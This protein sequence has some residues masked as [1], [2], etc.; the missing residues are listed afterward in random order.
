MQ[1]LTPWTAPDPVVRQLSDPQGFQKAVSPSGA[2]AK[3]ATIALVIGLLLLAYNLV[4][5]FRT[6]SEN[7]LGSESFFEVFTSTTGQNFSTDPMLVAYV[8]GPIVLIPL[9]IVFLVV[10]RLTVKQRAD[11]A[12]AAYSS[13]GYAAKALGL[14]VRFTANNSQVV[15][16][17]LVPPHLGSEEVS[18]WMSG[19]AQSITT[20]DKAGSKKL[21]KTLASKLAKPE[22][23]VLAETVF[24]GSPPFALLVQAPDAVGAETV[25]AVVP[26]DRST[27]AYVVDL[28]KVQGWG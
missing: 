9:A 28:S 15:P 19:V 11:R 3:A 4:S 1:T 7:D 10:S 13:G 22:V 18:R 25:R 17:V 8:W 14:P 23:A 2:A 5:T 20:L 27:R 16:Q 26:G 12:F 24:P 6:L 21:A